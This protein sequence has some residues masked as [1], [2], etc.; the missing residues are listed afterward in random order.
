MWNRMIIEADS[1][2]D[3]LI[4]EINYQLVI[5][6]DSLVAREREVDQFTDR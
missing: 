4:E 5:E 3:L 2:V 1:L 6:A